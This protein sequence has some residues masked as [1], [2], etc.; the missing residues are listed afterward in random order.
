MAQIEVPEALAVELR[1]IAL[2]DDRAFQDVVADAI[3]T[4][5]SCHHYEP[6]LTAAQVERMKQSI[7]QAECGE[8]ISQEKVE[9]F[10]EDWEKEIS[11][12]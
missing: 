6:E 3:N 9:A 10:F 7:A 1:E 11:S 8:L 2:R 4:Y 12:R 5:L